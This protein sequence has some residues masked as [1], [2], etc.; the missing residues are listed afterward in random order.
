M[1]SGGYLCFPDILHQTISSAVYKA[2]HLGAN[3]SNRSRD[4]CV[5]HVLTFGSWNCSS[6]FI[7]ACQNSVSMSSN[8]FL[9]FWCLF[10]QNEEKSQ[11]EVSFIPAH[12]TSILCFLSSLIFCVQWWNL[13]EHGGVFTVVSSYTCNCIVSDPVTGSCSSPNTC[14]HLYALFYA[15]A[16]FH[17]LT[18]NI[19]VLQSG[20]LPHLWLQFFFLCV[21]MRVHV[22]VCVFGVGA[23]MYT[24][25]LGAF[26]CRSFWR[27][28]IRKLR[29][30]LDASQE[31]VSALTTQ[32]SAN[33]RT[34]MKAAEY[35]Y[36]YT[37]S[38]RCFIKPQKIDSAVYYVPNNWQVILDK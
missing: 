6:F 15:S 7:K 17:L 23:A 24:L 22:Y 30:E 9:F 34:S 12:S 1:P 35:L 26:W 19:S 36:M 5:V 3:K 11:S 33:V 21:W 10:W 25:C 32:L 2:R 38:F 13:L 8:D 20:S 37:V 29:R 4:M 18:L 28:Q 14:V 16:A 27:P 31:K